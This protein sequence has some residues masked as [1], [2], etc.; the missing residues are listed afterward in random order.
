[1][2]VDAESHRVELSNI[3][4]EALLG[5]SGYELIGMKLSEFFSS[6]N[7][8]RVNAIMDILSASNGEVNE[9]DLEIRKKSGKSLGINLFASSLEMNRKKRLVIS[10]HDVTELKGR[11]EEKERSIR[12]M[13]HVS[14]LAD[15]GRLA[16]GVAHEL[17][18]PLMIIQGFAENIDLMCEDDPQVSSDELKWQVSPILKAADRMAKIISQLTRLSRNDKD[19]KLTHVDLIEVV[20]DIIGFVSNQFSYNDIEVVKDLQGGHLVKCDPNQIEQIILNIVSNAIHALAAVEDERRITISIR[21]EGKHEVLEIQNNGPAIP[22]SVQEKILTPFFTT[23]EIGEGTGLGLSVSYG[24]MKA[25]GGDLSFD[26][27][28]GTGTRFYMRF[29]KPQD[30]KKVFSKSQALG[31]VVDD[32]QG[33]RQVIASKLG[34]F[35]YQIIQAESAF[36]AL[37]ILKS[38]SNIEFIFTDIKMPKM[39]GS[40][41]IQEIRKNDRKVLV[42]AVSGFMSEAILDHHLSKHGV[43]GFLTKP[44]DHDKVSL[45]VGQIEDHLV[46]NKKKCA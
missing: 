5:Y 43:N 46:S 9:L 6:A 37:D 35:G 38:N 19:M 34:R 8:D 17:N 32:D 36:A 33:S 44:L 2:L 45:I 30:I 13:A 12:E 18:N 41:L 40:R 3:A 14:K 24:I 26:S 1:M 21:T 39:D 23:K 16:A 27:E 7:L 22:K 10:L 42:Y 31:L 15:I 29:P 11:Q 4:A 28:E 25:H 20:E